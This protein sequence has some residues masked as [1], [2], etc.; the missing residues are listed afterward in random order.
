M[1]LKEIEVGMVIHCKTQ[2]QAWDLVKH[3]NLPPHFASRHWNVYESDT[4]YYHDG[5]PDRWSYSDKN[6]FIN[7]HLEVIEFEDLIIKDDVT[8]PERPVLDSHIIC[9]LMDGDRL[10]FGG[11][12]NYMKID[13]AE[14]AQMIFSFDTGKTYLNLAVVPMSNIKYIRYIHSREEIIQ[15]L[16]EYNKKLSEDK[17][18]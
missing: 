7:E 11:M 4:C 1:K 8:L 12:C 5:F 3:S 10:D 14:P 6:Y 13:Y 16:E 17:E 9:E 18:D 2:D 15:A